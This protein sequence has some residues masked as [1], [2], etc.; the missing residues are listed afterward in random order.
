MKYIDSDMT[1]L[2]RWGYVSYIPT[3]VKNPR[4][5]EMIISLLKDDNEYYVQM[6]EA[7]L[8]CEIMIYYPEKT[9]LYLKNTDLKYNIIGKAIQKI[10]DS[11][12][13]SEEYKNLVKEIRKKYK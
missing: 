12:R 4:S 6:A 1:F 10:C 11:F 8:I 7:W 5:F 2:R 13:I 3:L 9:L